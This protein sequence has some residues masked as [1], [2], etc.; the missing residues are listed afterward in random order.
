M[1]SFTLAPNG[2]D[3]DTCL[4]SRRLKDRES[5]VQRR[6]A[7]KSKNAERNHSCAA[8]LPKGG[9]KRAALVRNLETLEASLLLGK[10][11]RRTSVRLGL[12]TIRRTTG[13]ENCCARKFWDNRQRTGRRKRKRQS[14]SPPESGVKS[15]NDSVRRRYVSRP[16]RGRRRPLQTHTHARLFVLPL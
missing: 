4:L 14:Q 16:V 3:C 9:G 5:Q 12:E 8:L 1:R 13:L 6:R 15:N 7:L 2:A 10:E 11:N